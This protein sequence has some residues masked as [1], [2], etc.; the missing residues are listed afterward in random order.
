MVNF[1]YEDLLISDRKSGWLK[2]YSRNA[3]VS[4]PW[5]G[6]IERFTPLFLRGS[7]FFLGWKS[8]FVI[9]CFAVYDL[10]N[11]FPIVPGLSGL[12]FYVR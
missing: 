8:L 4:M 9:S 6:F 11:F 5:T 2:F 1:N 12:P 7:V 3:G 10:F